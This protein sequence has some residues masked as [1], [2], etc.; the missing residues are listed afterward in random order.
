MSSCFR[1]F[2]E[3]LGK[4]M[5]LLLEAECLESCINFG[6]LHETAFEPYLAHEWYKESLFFWGGVLSQ[7]CNCRNG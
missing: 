3:A 2:V 4:D 6:P 5:I 1:C 7:C